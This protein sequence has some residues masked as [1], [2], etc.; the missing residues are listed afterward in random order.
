MKSVLVL[1]IC[2]LLPLRGWAEG[3]KPLLLRKPTINRTHVVFVY[4]G[5]L[6]GVNRQGGEARRLTSGIGVETDPIFS[7]DG[8]RIAFTGQYD[9]NQD[10][11][12]IP[13]EGGVPRR[14]TYHPGPDQVVGWSPD[15]KNVLFRSGRSSYSHFTRLFTIPAEGGYPTE[16]PLPTAYEGSYSPD[17]NRLAY[18]PLPPAFQIWKRYRGGRT[19]SIALAN[20]ADS[21][22]DK[23]PRENSNDFNPM[24]IGD[25]VYFLSDRNGPVTL[26][27][28]DPASREVVQVLAND[29]LDL[30]S[31]SAGPDAIVY[32]QFG[33]LYILELKTKQ[34][35]RLD[36]QVPAE[37]VEVRPHFVK[38]S[39]HIQNAALSPSGARAAFEARGE[40]ITVP[41]EK[42]DIRN[43]TN[44]P[45]VAERD[46]AWSPDGKWLAYFS[47]ESGEYLLHLK[48]PRGFTP[49]KKLALGQAPSFYFS[50][51]WSPDSK[52][53][54]YTDKRRNLWFI[55]LGTG[56]NTLV[57]TDH[58]ADASLDPA[59]SPDSRWIAYSKQLKNHLHAVFVHGL[60][61]GK[62]HQ[63]TDGMSDARFPA[64]DKNGKYLYFTASTDAGPALGWEMSGMNRPMTSSVY[65]VVLRQDLPSP[66]AP[67]SDEEKGTEDS[68][69]SKAAEKEKGKDA[70]PAAEAVR[71]DWEEID[72]RILALP[73]PARNYAGLEPG[74]AGILYLLERPAPGMEL[75]GFGEGPPPRTLYKFDLEKRKTD[76]SLEGVANVHLSQDGSKI[77]YKQ[78]Q[79]WLIASADQ[80]KP[81]EGTLKLDSMEIRVD[82]RAEWKQMY[83]EVW[84]LERDYLYDP[85]FHGLDLRAAEKKY[86]PYLDQ[87]A[88]RHDLTYL[89]SEM[90]GE[91]TLGHTY[92]F[93]GDAPEVKHV[94]GGLLGADYAVDQG[95]YRF[96]H[97]Y[98][99]QNWNPDLRAPL[100]QP[101]AK[102]KDG[103]YLLAVNGREVKAPENLYQFFEGTAGKSVVLK[104]GPNADGKGSRDVTVVP[105]ADEENLRHL[106]WIEA[107]RRKVDELSGGR[108]AYIYVPDT[109]QAG[110]ASFVRYFFAQVGKEG[111]VID[112]RFNGGG[113]VADYIVDTLRRHLICYTTFREGED[114]TVPLGAIFGPKAMIINEMAGSGGDE[115]PHYFRQT[116]VGPLIG[117]RTW[118]GLVGL[119]D[120]P[121][122]ID[123]GIVTAPSAGFY[124]PS[125]N[126]EVE[127]HGVAPDIEVD[128][129]PAAVRSGH[130]PQLERAVAVLMEELSKNPPVKPKRPAYP[131]YHPRNG[132]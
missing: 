4:G 51:L 62:H 32:E 68:K 63:V 59:W 28:Y 44:S 128:L 70:K 100:T 97:V 30:K 23:I 103:E 126:W 21:H 81:G 94:G 107:N 84:R 61:T 22:I 57:D 14:L 114:A 56:K 82:P 36:V 31:A 99:G 66:L 131:N 29:G 105:I 64:F 91:L 55:D 116:K 121:P 104:V 118:G 10:V 77:L 26:F 52:K 117:K 13:A 98:L 108:L 130:D 38:G 72:Q 73:I 2:L 129:D 78:G 11:F 12:I 112:E 123:G 93:G 119:E 85:G 83:H 120:Y 48:E 41:A 96:A 45:G 86:E 79:N 46:P 127:N 18:V 102:V 27:A 8:G 74:K 89:F 49:A 101:G 40:I 71:I 75:G 47:D 3:G 1:G 76:K 88:S 115:L 5:D 58:Y 25:K 42:G 16:L 9:G 15:G 109:A 33:S 24:W 111:A 43:L 90:L 50:P 19:S 34:A 6:W 20:L 124:F 60:E 7:P 35:N 80:P 132:K 37:L 110:Y 122:L 65:M 113:I 69:G 106:A 17:G 54:A 92:V 95:R 87:L 125:G 53:I 67:E 39:K